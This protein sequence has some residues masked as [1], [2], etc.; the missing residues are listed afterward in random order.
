MCV[1]FKKEIATKISLA[2]L[3]ECSDY[4]QIFN[5][6]SQTILSFEIFGTKASC[7]PSSY[8]I[9]RS[10]KTRVNVFKLTNIINGKLV[11]SLCFS[12]K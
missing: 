5:K 6:F 1:L 3:K 7:H 9:V 4:L 11:H 10:D 12:L 2:Y 8:F